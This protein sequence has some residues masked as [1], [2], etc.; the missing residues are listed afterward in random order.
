M[1]GEDRYNDVLQKGE[2]LD[3]DAGSLRQQGWDEYHR[4]AGRM[5]E[6][7]ARITGGSSDWAAVVRRLQQVHPPSIEG[8]R[9]EY[10]AVC[11]EARRFMI[12]EGLV[13]DPPDERCEVVPAPPAVRATLAVACYIAPPMFKPSRVGYFF[14]PYP[15]DAERRRGGRRPPREQRHL[16]D[17]HHRRARGLPRATTGT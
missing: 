1:F 12:D 11:L 13:T 8:M 15:V 10:E 5:G 4:V 16:L 9:A 14:V 17:G 7:A 6:V 2:L 3:T